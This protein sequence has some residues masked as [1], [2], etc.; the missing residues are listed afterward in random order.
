M[1][2]LILFLPAA[3]C[4]LMGLAQQD[5]QFSQNMFNHLGVNPAAAGL[6]KGTC[7]KMLCRSQWV[8]FDGAP[9]TGLISADTWLPSIKSGIGLNVLTDKIGFEKNFAARLAYSKHFDLPVG[10]LAAGLEAGVVQ[11]SISGNWLAPTNAANDNAIP[12]PSI[13]A[14]AYDIG[15]G[16][17][18]RSERLYAGL[19]TSHIPES[20]VRQGSVSFTNRMHHYVTA[21]FDQD[22][23]PRVVLSPSVFVKSD[24]SSTQVDANVITVIDNMVWLGASYRLTDAVV[25][26]GGIRLGDWKFGYSFDLTTSDLR[27][28]SSNTHE[29]FISYCFKRPEHQSSHSNSRWMW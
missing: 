20:S 8:G 27:K 19:S 25:A 5:V 9:R 17:Y 21:G 23:T 12:S 24:A 28:Y 11:K 15:A 7:V 3:L 14:S 1:K 22:I 2:T 29:F 18:F 16:V 26:L 4:G 13:S 10:I 6:T